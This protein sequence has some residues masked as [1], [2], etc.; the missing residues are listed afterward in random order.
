MPRGKPFAKGHSGNPRGRK[1][2][3]QAEKDV[4]VLAKVHT[5]RAIQRL[6]EIME[7]NNEKAAQSAAA[8]LLDRAHGRPEQKVDMNLH[9]QQ[10]DAAVQRAADILGR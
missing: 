6:A 7:S 9:M 8:T 4:R 5:E 10:F 1:P 2:L 3:S